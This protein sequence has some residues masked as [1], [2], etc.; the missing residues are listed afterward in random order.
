MQHLW[1]AP[2][3]RI[4]LEETDVSKTSIFSLAGLFG[5]Q[6]LV[7][8]DKRLV[9]FKI[10][11]GKGDLDLGDIDT[12]IMLIDIKRTGSGELMVGTD[13]KG[14][15]N[16][17][18]SPSEFIRGISGTEHD[19]FLYVCT[20]DSREEFLFGK[21]RKT[22]EWE[23]K[24]KTVVNTL[25]P[26]VKKEGKRTGFFGI[27]RQ[28]FT[29]MIDDLKSGEETVGS[30]MAHAPT[31]YDRPRNSRS[32]EDQISAFCGAS[33]EGSRE[34][35]DD[36][37]NAHDQGK[38]HSPKHS[39][40]QAFKVKRPMIERACYNCGA[41]MIGRASHSVQCEYCGTEYTMG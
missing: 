19:R 10:P 1:L 18:G 28:G 13:V 37:P 39:K 23:E 40:P 32:A 22:Y 12:E 30:Q 16:L 14:G 33:S 20:R 2:G 34:A 27:M 24:I 25:Y 15:V 38:N 3:E 8:T 5:S 11:S 26:S 31:S 41:K 7:L 21:K 17:S 9:Y 36:I 35:N 29:D 6:L 4:V